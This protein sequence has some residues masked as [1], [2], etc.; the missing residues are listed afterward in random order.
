[1]TRKSV[2][3]CISRGL[4]LTFFVVYA[5][6]AFSYINAPLHRPHSFSLLEKSEKHEHVLQV[7][8][9]LFSKMAK[10]VACALEAG[11]SVKQCA[12]KIHPGKK[13]FI[14][15]SQKFTDIQFLW[16]FGVVFNISLPECRDGIVDAVFQKSE[17]SSLDIYGCYQQSDLSPPFV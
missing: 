14:L 6:S 11:D 4:F 13:K 2:T 7:Q 16:S 10:R 9:H 17:H 3:G 8:D 5:V 15:R 12:D 1:M